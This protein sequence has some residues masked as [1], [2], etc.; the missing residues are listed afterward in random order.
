MSTPLVFSTF[1]KVVKKKLQ[2]YQIFLAF[3]CLGRRKLVSKPCLKKKKN[4][5]LIFERFRA[6][7]STQIDVCSFRNPPTLAFKSQDPPSALQRS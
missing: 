5:E 4:P 6:S 1:P 2:I 7:F 3:F